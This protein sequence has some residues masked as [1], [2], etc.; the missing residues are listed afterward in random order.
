MSY[1]YNKD[2]TIKKLSEKDFYNGI[3]VQ[4]CGDVGA[5]Y[6]LRFKK[7]E[8]RHKA[9]YV[10]VGRN[11]SLQSIDWEDYGALELEQYKGGIWMRNGISSSWCE[12]VYTNKINIMARESKIDKLIG[13]NKKEKN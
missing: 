4:S 9:T 3:I 10:I 6:E 7:G 11:E 8:W 2:I 1:N 12:T 13:K 5:I